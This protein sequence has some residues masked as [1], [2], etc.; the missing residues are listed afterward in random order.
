MKDFM[1]ALPASPSSLF[2]HF[3]K[4][5]MWAVLVLESARIIIF[6]AKSLKSFPLAEDLSYGLIIKTLNL[7]IIYEIFITL[8]SALEFRRIKLTYVVDTAL[9]FFIR[10]L[11][12]ITFSDKYI[13]P[14]TAGAF[15]AVIASL[16][17]LR[18]VAVKFSPTQVRHQAL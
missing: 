7:L 3:L 15:V 16:G 13:D 10:E 12:V 5:V 18:V 14:K 2:F 1:K 17:I 8:I 4:L 9:V 6:T 11:I